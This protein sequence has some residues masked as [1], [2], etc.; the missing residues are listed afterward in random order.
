MGSGKQSP[1][2]GSHLLGP[3]VV[4]R[5]V[6]VRRLLRGQTGPT[7]GPAFTDVLGVCLAW[8]DG[9]CVV[10]PEAG[11][12]VSIPVPDIVSGKPV[13]PRPSVRHRVSPRE[14]Q[15]HSLVMWPEVPTLEL[16][17][18]V[19]RTARPTTRVIARASSALA[20]GDPGLPL[21]EAAA[22]LV[23]HYAEAGLPAWAQ[24]VADS[25]EE[26]GLRA[27]GWVDARPDEADSLF[28][29]A[30]LSRVVRALPTSEIAVALDLEG[31]RALATVGEVAHG[32][33]AVDGD[34]VGIHDLW[35][36]PGHRRQALNRA[37]LAEL[38]DWAASQGALTAYLQVRADNRPALALYE[39]LGFTTHHAYRYLAA[40]D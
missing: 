37:V 1:D 26:H 10:Q 16:G 40:P 24:V 39:R 3:H 11:P 31:P 23:A 5:R 28:Q 17:E 22:V 12:A 4:G 7:G 15:L 33:A 8:A 36:D 35:T 34:W 29:I 19:L 20:M 27:L 25:P 32:R 38:L 30:P 21:A 14:A 13:P 9:V 18:W 2:L 6:V